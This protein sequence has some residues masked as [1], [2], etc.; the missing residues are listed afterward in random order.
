EDVCVWVPVI[1][2]P[3]EEGRRRSEGRADLAP[4]DEVACGAVSTAEEGV[5]RTA[6]PEAA[7]IR[8][9]EK[10]V[11]LRNGGRDR[12]LGVDVLAGLEG[13][14][15]HRGVGSGRRQVQH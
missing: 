2:S 15:D 5:G 6:D 14:A 12:L 10:L 11:A 13:S 7:T 9:C 3:D 1:R 8:L 4:L